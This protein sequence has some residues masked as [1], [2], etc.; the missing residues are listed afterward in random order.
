MLLSMPTS[1]TRKLSWVYLHEDIEE[2]EEA[3]SVVRNYEEYV[4]I[5]KL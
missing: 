5:K 1:T 3:E 4:E 2:E